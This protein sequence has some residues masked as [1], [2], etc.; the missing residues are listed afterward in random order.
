MNRAT[1]DRWLADLPDL[2]KD[3]KAALVRQYEQGG[4]SQDSAVR[5]VRNKLTVAPMTK[6]ATPFA[7]K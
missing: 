4:E 1:F 5:T 2:S 6:P 3:E 7:S